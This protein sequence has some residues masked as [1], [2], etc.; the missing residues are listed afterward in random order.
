[1]MIEIGDSML[2]CLDLEQGVRI[3]K[4]TGKFNPKVKL[5]ILINL[6]DAHI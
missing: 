2:P 5:N 1:M 6:Y 4:E 3:L